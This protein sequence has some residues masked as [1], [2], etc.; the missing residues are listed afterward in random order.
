MK[1]KKY[2]QVTD[3]DAIK[4]EGI[5]K[6]SC[7]DCGLVHVWKLQKTK[8][9]VSYWIVKRDNR[10]TGQLRKN[11]SYEYKKVHPRP[12]CTTYPLN[13]FVDGF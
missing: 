9:N 2:I 13:Q 5:H 4:M 3:N 6:I 11:K 1:A 10:A 8:G 7:C 12:S